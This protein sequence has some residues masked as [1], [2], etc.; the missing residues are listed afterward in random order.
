MN[1]QKL[2]YLALGTPTDSSVAKS[3]EASAL[4]RMVM[5]QVY[6]LDNLVR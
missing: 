6:K 1:P 4:P 5:M 2:R 3:V